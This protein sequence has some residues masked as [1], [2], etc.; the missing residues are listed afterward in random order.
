MRARSLDRSNSDSNDTCQIRWI[1]YLVVAQMFFKAISLD[2]LY[3]VHR[4]KRFWDTH[5]QCLQ[6]YEVSL[7]AGRAGFTFWRLHNSNSISKLWLWKFLASGRFWLWRFRARP[8]WAV[9][10]E[11]VDFRGIGPILILNFRFQISSFGS[12]VPNLRF[13]SQVTMLMPLQNFIWLRLVVICTDASLAIINASWCRV[14][15]F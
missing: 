3:I 1:C 9:A 12:M 7:L 6:R 13:R 11:G 8:V 14:C 15:T 4:Q 5:L 2:M 10:W